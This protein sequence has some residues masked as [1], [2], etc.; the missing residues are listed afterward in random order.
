MNNYL[1]TD[2]NKYIAINTI[3]SYIS[4]LLNNNEYN[5]ALN[6]YSE[7][8]QTI[9]NSILLKTK[10]SQI[11]SAITNLI[12]NETNI[13]NIIIYT[14]Q[15]LKEKDNFRHVKLLDLPTSDKIKDISQITNANQ[16]YDF[17]RS[18]HKW[19]YFNCNFKHFLTKILEINIS[20]IQLYL[21]DRET[22]F[23]W[24]NIY[25]EIINNYQLNGNN[26]YLI[27]TIWY[28]ELRLIYFLYDLINHKMLYIFEENEDEKKKYYHA[29]LMTLEIDKLEKELNKYL[30]ENSRL[31]NENAELRNKLSNLDAKNVEMNNQM[32]KIS[33]RNR[34]LETRE[35]TNFENNN[36]EMEKQKR[37]IES[38]DIEIQSLKQAITQKD[39]EYSNNVQRMTESTEREK[40]DALAQLTAEMEK[41]L[42]TLVDEEKNKYDV[43]SKELKQS[44]DERVK[45]LKSENNDLQLKINQLH[46]E[47]I[48]INTKLTAL[49]SERDKLQTDYRELRIAFENSL[50]KYSVIANAVDNSAAI[51]KI[52]EDYAT[53]NEKLQK[54]YNVLTE[55]YNNYYKETSERLNVC[56][57]LFQQLGDIFKKLMALR[58]V[59]DGEINV[60]TSRLQTNAA[61]EEKEEEGRSTIF[62]Y[63]HNVVPKID[64]M[65][66]EII[67]ACKNEKEKSI[68]MERAYNNE[69]EKIIQM[70]RIIS[71]VIDILNKDEKGKMGM[72]LM[73]ML[74]TSANK[75]YDMY[76]EGREENIRNLEQKIGEQKQ[77]INIMKE[78]NNVLNKHLNIKE[79]YEQ[80]Q[81]NLSIISQ[82][83]TLKEK[84]KETME[85]LSGKNQS[86]SSSISKILEIV[87]KQDEVEGDDENEVLVIKEEHSSKYND[88]NSIMLI[89]IKDFILNLKRELKRIKKIITKTQNV[90]SG[91]ELKIKIEKEK[92]MKKQELMEVTQDIDT[93]LIEL[94]NEFDNQSSK[95]NNIMKMVL[96]YCKEYFKEILEISYG[97]EI[98]FLKQ[99]QQQQESYDNQEFFE[100]AVKHVKKIK[101]DIK[102]R[103]NEIKQ[104]EISLSNMVTIV[105]TK[106]NDMTIQD[107]AIKKEKF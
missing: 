62:L 91:H 9:L 97:T 84:I 36:L 63:S 89:R 104:K 8:L 58:G 95:K 61:V 65:I 101:D 106:L 15:M 81:E 38:R 42:Q 92:E 45:V 69:K 90:L 40:E 102:E 56:D 43:T 29:N 17:I 24:K 19:L 27:N 60:N 31:T 85:M 30:I 50:Q 7:C 76:I 22:I 34:E 49:S 78:I 66:D 64:E 77:M 72:N 93:Q 86:I 98:E 59:D 74:S 51:K 28:Q 33:T 105:E 21:M 82:I 11:N 88:E 57:Y 26:L 96:N 5:N 103:L 3:G 13:H 68:E 6:T 47:K 46:H 99:Q 79:D 12:D 54:K 25:E 100:T 35:N 80:E 73:D 14:I 32:E 87:N 44:F 37:E 107:K 16:I 23:Q 71:N 52:S 48:S 1:A 18:K 55:Q 83:Y 67:L 41:K 2:G 53:E 75:L 39:N 10:C 94:F 20:N 70:E 4:Q